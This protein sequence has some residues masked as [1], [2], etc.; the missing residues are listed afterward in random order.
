LSM[1]KESQLD[2]V[3]TV[4]EASKHLNMPSST[5]YR[6]IKKGEVPCFKEGKQWK[7]KRSTLIQWLENRNKKPSIEWKPLGISQL[8]AGGQPVSI[9]T[10]RLMDKLGYWRRYRVSTVQEFYSKRA[11]RIPAWGRL[12]KDSQGKIGVLV[13]GAHYGLMKIGRSR[14]AQ[15][16]LLSS[17]NALSKKACKSLLNQIDYE[18]FEEDNI[19]LAR[20]KQGS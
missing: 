7:F 8:S 14:Q 18:L 20:E 13:T 11:T 10:V 2:K 16:Y 3:F 1:E 4:K 15:V 9:R 17:F 5:L 19:I 12:V 6:Y